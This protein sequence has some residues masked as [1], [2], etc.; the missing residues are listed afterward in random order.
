MLDFWSWR[1]TCAE[2]SK[3]VER[4]ER[5]APDRCER[6]TP[7]YFSAS[8]RRCLHRWTPAMGL[9][10]MAKSWPQALQCHCAARWTVSVDSQF[11]QGGFV[12]STERGAPCFFA[13]ANKPRSFFFHVRRVKHT[14][15]LRPFFLVAALANVCFSGA[16]CDSMKLFS[17]SPEP[18]P[19]PVE[20]FEAAR[21]RRES[22]LLEEI[23]KL[24]EQRDTMRS[25]ISTF[26]NEHIGIVGGRVVFMT[27]D[28]NSRDV[29]A[30]QWSAL[31]SGSERK[32]SATARCQK[33]EY[34]ELHSTPGGSEHSWV[35]H[36]SNS[37]W[38]RWKVKSP[39]ACP[40]FDKIGRGATGWKVPVGSTRRGTTSGGRA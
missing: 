22:E 5:A 19:A 17:K 16:S 7:D 1:P 23:R 4:S 39:S 21:A 32:T 13:Q 35:T 26:K 33:A 18:E 25:L 31:V 12:S 27:S 40:R 10:S 38:R 14:G 34:S 20:S 29:L 3:N 9:R 2:N 28:F 8:L 24:D 11:G 30:S 15:E 6:V 37:S 36:S